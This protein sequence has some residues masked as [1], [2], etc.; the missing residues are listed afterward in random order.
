M[1]LITAHSPVWANIEHTCID[2]KVSFA[3]LPD[4]DLPFTANPHDSEIHGRDIFNRAIAGE[5]GP[6]MEYTPP[7]PPTQEQQAENVRIERNKLLMKTDWTQG[8]DIPQ[9]IKDKWAPYRQALRDIS[10]QDG[11]PFNVVWP[12]PPN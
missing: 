2:L 3:E 6:I 8:A 5:F 11:F 7:P 10:L 9:N 4:I 1:K 12:V